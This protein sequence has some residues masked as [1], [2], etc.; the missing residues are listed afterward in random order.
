[1]L[2][3]NYTMECNSNSVVHYLKAYYISYRN[4]E[5]VSKNLVIFP[6]SSSKDY[7]VSMPEGYIGLISALETD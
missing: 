3:C 1:M 2:L 5:P 4:E 7:T 6:I